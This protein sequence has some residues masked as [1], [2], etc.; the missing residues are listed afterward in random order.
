MNLVEIFLAL[1][2]F[3]HRKHSLIEVMG[4]S[5]SEFLCSG[6]NSLR[7]G[8]VWKLSESKLR[9]EKNPACHRKRDIFTA[10]FWVVSAG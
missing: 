9:E 2:T 5:D 3:S 10:L 1:V 6:K 8:K 7:H 4:P